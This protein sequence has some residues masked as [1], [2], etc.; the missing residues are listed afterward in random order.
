M[1]HTSNERATETVLFAGCVRGT[2]ANYFPF[3][4]DQHAGSIFSL[5]QLAV[6]VKG[7]KYG[8]NKAVT[9]SA[10][11]DALQLWLFPQLEES[12]P[13]NFIWQQDGVPPH[14]H[15]SA[16]DWLNITVPKQW[17]G[18][19]EIPDKACIVWPPRSPDLTPCDFYL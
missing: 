7:K 13:N 9:G 8:T 5:K 1:T 2:K 14:W 10:Y 12:E 18:H 15:I 3:L 17:I 11:L 19:K 4:A 16:H 6:S